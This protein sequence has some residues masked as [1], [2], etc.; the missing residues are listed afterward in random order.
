MAEISIQPYVQEQN[1]VRV[2]KMGNKPDVGLALENVKLRDYPKPIRNS[3][4][5]NLVEWMANKIGVN[6]KEGIE[7]VM[8]VA[9][10]HINKTLVN[11][12][13][14]E[15][16]LAFD[17]FV[18]RELS[19][20][21]KIIEPFAELNA[22]VIGRVMSA[23]SEYKRKELNKYLRI[24]AEEDR[25]AEEEKTKPSESEKQTILVL[26]VLN[27]YEEFKDF[28]YIPNGKSFVYDIMWE[29][30][31]LPP[32]TKAFRKEIGILA[33]EKVNRESK[34]EQA[35]EFKKVIKTT[36]DNAGAVK[37]AAKKIVL[38]M[39]F[40]NLKDIEELKEKIGISL[41]IQ[42]ITE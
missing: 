4:T 39:A 23:Y 17:L 8:N 33:Q 12:T 18:Q 24:R 14:Q 19:L 40:D 37:V 28:G 42:R 35:T 29:W 5:V 25:I 31:L 15:I 34:I 20:E 30:Q 2:V 27:A 36:E 16:M 22:R 10:Q 32:H 9:F 38:K 11:Y 26:S 7:D 1:K 3:N 41:K 21:N 6:Q 13:Y